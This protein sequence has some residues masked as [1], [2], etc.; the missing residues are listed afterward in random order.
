ME[1]KNTVAVCLISL[2]SATLVLLIA[3]ALD[4]QA[5]SRLEPQLTSIVEELQAI[6]KSGGMTA[7]SDG[8]A[9][10]Q[11]VSNALMVYYFH[12]NTR[13][14]TC[15]A[16]ESQSQATVQSDFAPQA[17]SGEV[18]WRILNY[19]QPAG[20]ELAKKFGVAMPVV[21]LARMK[22][23]RIEDWKRLDRVWALVGNKPAFAEYV[24]DEIAQMLQVTGPQ[25]AALPGDPPVTDVPR[26]DPGEIVDPGDIPVPPDS[27]AI[28]LPE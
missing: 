20:A 2:F 15:R 25:T 6:R 13:C 22:G 27:V 19:E 11:T 26:V 4:L 28:P 18:A 1:L 10:S 16:I 7:T 17:K 12:G 23:G 8:A 9:E 14:P 24:R 21:V 3:R 5:A